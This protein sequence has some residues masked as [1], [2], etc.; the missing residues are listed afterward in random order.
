MIVIKEEFVG[1]EKWRRAFKLGRSD[2]IVMWIALKCYAS[3]HPSAEGFVPDEDIDELPGAPRA[4]RRALDALVHC[5]RLQSDGSRGAGLV[6]AVDGGWRLHDYLD[7]APPPEEL[8]LRREKAR[9][10]KQRQRESQRRELEEVRAQRRDASPGTTG[11]T[12]GDSS[13]GTR[14]AVEGD[15]GG[16]SEGTVPGVS[17]AGAGAPALGR[18]RA[19][20]RPQPNP[21]Q[22]NPATGGESA[23]P[24]E[25]VQTASATRFVPASWQPN[26]AHRARCAELGLDLERCAEAFR[27]TEFQRPY[28]DWDRRFAKFLAGERT[29]AETRRF[30]SSGAPSVRRATSSR[31]GDHGRTGFEALGRGR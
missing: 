24:L 20:A 7:H 27:N 12:G 17:L 25:R 16:D 2:A 26:A 19:A 23:P 11:G 10:K 3:Q 9:L 6:E 31:Q 8:E 1:G 14:S 5:G 29:E 22:P 4:A 21:T 13:P 15:T 18:P 28:T 30:Q